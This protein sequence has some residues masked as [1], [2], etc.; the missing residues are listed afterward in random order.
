MKIH[1]D[2]LMIWQSGLLNS[3]PKG[4]LAGRPAKSGRK[5]PKVAESGRKWPKLNKVILEPLNHTNKVHNVTKTY[6]TI[7]IYILVQ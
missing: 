4:V 6:H 2:L 3:R 5:W 7:M 1:N